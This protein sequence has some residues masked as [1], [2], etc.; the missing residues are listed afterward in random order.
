MPLGFGRIR[1]RPAAH[2]LAAD[3]GKARLRNGVNQNR[4]RSSRGRKSRLDRFE[5]LHPALC[6]DRDEGR[7]E[8]GW[9]WLQSSV[10][11]AGALGG[12]A[13]GGGVVPL[14]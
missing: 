9:R 8:D 2:R 12:G 1:L 11:W 10:Y 7:D 5:H 3:T 6:A 4:L 14:G 13:A